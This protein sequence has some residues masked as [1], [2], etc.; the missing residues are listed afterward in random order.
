MPRLHV[1]LEWVDPIEADPEVPAPDGT[2][3]AIA[4]AS[5]QDATAAVF[6]HTYSNGDGRKGWTVTTK[7]TAAVFG[8][9]AGTP[10]EEDSPEFDTE[11]AAR[12]WAEVALGIIYA[13][14]P[15]EWGGPDNA[16]DWNP[17]VEELPEE[18]F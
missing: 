1:A 9:D 11:D 10:W 13:P 17:P 18:P 12:D 6:Q 5:H 7:Y 2:E 14:D 3:G 8:G 15:E 16:E 4:Y